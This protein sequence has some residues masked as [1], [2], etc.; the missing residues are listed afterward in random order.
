MIEKAINKITSLQ[1]EV[2][3]SAWLVGEQLKDFCRVSE[4]D[5]EILLQD[6]EIPEM[7]L[8]K[9]E[10]KIKEYA[11]QNVHEGEACVSF[12]VAE[13]ILRK[14]YCL[15]PRAETTPYT[16]HQQ[17]TQPVSSDSEKIA[18]EMP[19]ITHVVKLNLDDFL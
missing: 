18:D 12:Q 5:A 1:P 9:A 4:K 2:H 11:D 17:K 10:R 14:F 19:E 7:S 3:N 13:D 8:K 6:L 16:P 15:T